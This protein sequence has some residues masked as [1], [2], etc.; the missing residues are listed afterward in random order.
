MKDGN[1]RQQLRRWF[2]EPEHLKADLGKAPKECVTP[3]VNDM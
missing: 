2:I 3:A 1:D